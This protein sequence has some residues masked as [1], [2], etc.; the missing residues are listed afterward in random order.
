LEG[1]GIKIGMVI[2]YCFDYQIFSMKFLNT[3]PLH[4]YF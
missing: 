1:A 2:L 4:F 3:L